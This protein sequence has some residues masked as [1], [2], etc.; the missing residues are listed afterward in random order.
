ML[1]IDI[2]PD[3]KTAYTWKQSTV[4][5]WGW[6]FLEGIKSFSEGVV[7]S[8]GYVVRKTIAEPL[9]LMYK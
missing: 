7:K 2:N 4:A 1:D 6:G 9:K 5:S 3:G 8:V